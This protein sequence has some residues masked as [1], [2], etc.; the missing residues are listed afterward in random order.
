MPGAPAALHGAGL[1]S[2]WTRHIG[3]VFERAANTYDSLGVELFGPVGAALVDQ[4]RIRQGQAVL[5][6]GCGRGASLI[7][8]A[9]A[10]GPSG[11][12]TGIDI[13]PTMVRH[14]NATLATLDLAHAR[15]IVADAA[16]PAFPDE[17]FDAIIAGFVVFFL[18]DIEDSLSSYH[19]LLRPGGR[20]AMTV[21]PDDTPGQ[22][23]IKQCVEQALA[24]FVVASPVPAVKPAP[25]GRTPEAT[26]QLLGNA[27]FTGI[28]II[29]AIH[30]VRF[31]NGDHY[32]RWLWS[33]GT[34]EILEL[35]PPHLVEPARASVIHAL[36]PCLD[37]QGRLP[38]PVPV[39]LA[40]AERAP[41]GTATRRSRSNEP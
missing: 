21:R 18:P 15:A 5:D 4:A 10:V 19:R 34:R 26:Y 13:A 22:T 11:T 28:R 2:D 41:R 3:G 9:L 32:W 40:I 24:P 36:T 6:V 33:H 29:D 23:A 30:L 37:A 12:V 25:L 8:A 7:P 38:C 16:Q 20:I 39:R 27:K 14:T 31:D 35:I 17:T 1:S